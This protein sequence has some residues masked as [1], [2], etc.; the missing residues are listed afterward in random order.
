LTLGWSSTGGLEPFSTT[1]LVVA[2]NWGGLFG[3]MTVLEELACLAFA[4]S[5]LWVRVLHRPR[6]PRSSP[7]QY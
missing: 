1:Q 4:D 5:N 7:W 3:E 2:D 6:L